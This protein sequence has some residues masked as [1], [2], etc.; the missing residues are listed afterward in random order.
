MVYSLCFV[1][2]FQHAVHAAMSGIT[3]CSGNWQRLPIGRAQMLTFLFF[4]MEVWYLRDRSTHCVPGEI[5]GPEENSR[6]IPEF[7]SARVPTISSFD[8]F[9]TLRCSIHEKYN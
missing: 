6:V 3:V 8:I 9:D 2:F 7:D 5:P 1:I 4:A